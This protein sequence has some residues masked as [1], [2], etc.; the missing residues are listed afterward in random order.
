MN[1]CIDFDG[2][3]VSHKFPLIGKDIG[4]VPVLKELVINGHNLI[5]FTMRSDIENPASDDHMIHNTGG[6]YLT[7]AICWFKENGIPLW[8][9]Q[10]NPEQS[11]W[12][13]SPKA[14]GHMYID[15]AALGVPLIV[16]PFSGERPY[17]DWVEVRNILINK[18]LIQTKN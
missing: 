6:N 2:T 13:T 11:S 17:V 8:G 3:C 16:E 5:L 4:S 12:T 7:E 14:Y 15:D 18:G 10:T 9:I 1:I